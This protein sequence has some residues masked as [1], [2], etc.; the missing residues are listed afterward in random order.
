M[1]KVGSH[2]RGF[3]ER[4]P[5]GPP[6][7]RAMDDLVHSLIWDGDIESAEKIAEVMLA[8]AVKLHDHRAGYGFEHWLATH[9][10]LSTMRR[11]REVRRVRR[12]KR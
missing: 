9:D 10:V 12:G 7:P 6:S 2:V 1:K 8:R 5:E 3:W 11:S 4:Q